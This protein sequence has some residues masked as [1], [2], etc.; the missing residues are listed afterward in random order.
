MY[1]WISEDICPI[2][3]KP[4][5]TWLTDAGQGYVEIDI[6]NGYAYLRKNKLIKECVE[7]KKRSEEQKQCPTK[8]P[9]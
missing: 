8:S 2:C 1:R 4:I 5:S 3:N 6:H 9:S 7:L